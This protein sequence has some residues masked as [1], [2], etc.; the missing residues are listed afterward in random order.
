[1]A[2]Q[3]KTRPN[4]REVLRSIEDIYRLTTTEFRRTAFEYVVLASD[5]LNPRQKKLMDT[6]EQKFTHELFMRWGRGEI[7]TGFVQ[8][9]DPEATEEKLTQIA[10]C[11]LVHGVEDFLEFTDQGL[12]VQPPQYIEDKIHTSPAVATPEPEPQ[13]KHRVPLFQGP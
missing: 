7:P 11:H 9:F 2:N 1:M 8:H 3:Y 5:P 6:V 4:E 12:P 13:W 10:L